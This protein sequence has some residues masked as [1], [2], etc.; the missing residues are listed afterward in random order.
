MAD[1]R[2]LRAD[3]V[4]ALEIIGVRADDG[5][6]GVVDDVLELTGA[7]AIVDR[8]EHGADLRDG[9]ERLELRVGVRRD[10]RDAVAARD[11][12]RLQRRR[13]AVAPIEE[14]RVGEPQR[15]V[16]E[17]LALRVQRARAPRELQRR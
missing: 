9:V 12:E 7:Q 8:H 15:A 13:P 2:Q 5:R 1:A 16:D 6:A 17:R 14:L 10:V 11:A 3:A 4:E